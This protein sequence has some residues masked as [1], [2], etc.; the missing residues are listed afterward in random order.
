MSF[1]YRPAPEV[2][3][4]LNAYCAETGVTKTWALNMALKTWLPA[5]SSTAIYNNV[6]NANANFSTFNLASGSSASSVVPTQK[7]G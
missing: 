7:E 5:A 6:T 1:T 3:A 4:A 2:D